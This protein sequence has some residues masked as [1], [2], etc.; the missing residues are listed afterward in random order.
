MSSVQLSVHEGDENSSAFRDEFM[1]AEEKNISVA[2]IG[3][4]P[5]PQYF[6]AMIYGSMGNLPDFSLRNFSIAFGARIKIPT[7]CKKDTKRKLFFLKS[8]CVFTCHRENKRSGGGHR[9]SQR[10]M[11]QGFFSTRA[12]ENYRLHKIPISTISSRVPL[13]MR[14]L[15]FS[16]PG[17][18][19]GAMSSAIYVIAN[20]GK[21][22]QSGLE[23][24]RVGWLEREEKRGGERKGK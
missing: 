10:Q 2:H 5:R 17:A 3:I 6:Y 7:V 15:N 9:M 21:G 18:R 4:L 19:W 20:L 14:S 22:E 11:S 24:P 8:C 23:V 13:R 16:V 12:A 1:S